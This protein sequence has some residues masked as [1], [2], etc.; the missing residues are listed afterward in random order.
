MHL[1][2]DD[3]SGARDDFDVVLLGE[4]V[5]GLRP[6]LK[7]RAVAEQTNDARGPVKRVEHDGDAAVAGFVEVRDGLISAAAKVHVPEGLVVDQPEVEA[8]FRRDIDVPRR[9]ERRSGHPEHLLLEDPFHQVFGDR[10]KKLAHAVVVLRLSS[11][12]V[13]GREARIA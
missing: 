3:G 10:L 11:S 8:P 2:Y 9:R 6:A 7:D 13:A 12:G 5:E 1:D 4:V